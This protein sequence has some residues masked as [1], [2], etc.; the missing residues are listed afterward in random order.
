MFFITFEK[1]F[2]ALQLDQPTLK[3]KL[4][5]GFA[6]IFLIAF[7]AFR[8]VFRGF[9]SLESKIRKFL[10]SNKTLEL[11]R[12]VMGLLSCSTSRSV[13]DPPTRCNSIWIFTLNWKH[14]FSWV[15]QKKLLIHIL[16]FDLSEKFIL[17]FLLKTAAWKR[18][19]AI[20][21]RN[22]KTVIY[23]PQLYWISL[24]F[25]PPQPKFG[26]C[27]K[28]AIR[29]PGWAMTGSISAKAREKFWSKIYIK[30]LKRKLLNFCKDF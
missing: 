8:V 5:H 2:Q 14:K 26:E 13:L 24:A 7:S 19:N 12:R 10:L 6:N 16:G 15:E 1:I 9:H 18:F 25:L 30:L 21:R 27:W 3:E 28:F 20:R 4:S 11:H 17:S 22:V 23:T 29:R